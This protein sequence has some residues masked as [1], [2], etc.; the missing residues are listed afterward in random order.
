[1]WTVADMV[2]LPTDSF[3]T[4]TVLLSQSQDALQKG[5]VEA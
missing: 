1:M 2:Y 5:A 4:K 3:R